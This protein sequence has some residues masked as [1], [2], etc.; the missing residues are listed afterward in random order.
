MKFPPVHDVKRPD[1]LGNKINPGIL[2]PGRGDVL[3]NLERLIARLDNLEL[4]LAVVDEVVVY[5][6][7]AQE[8]A[9]ALDDGTKVR[10]TARWVDIDNVAAFDAAGV[11]RSS[12]RDS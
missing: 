4:V 12:Q 3:D 7:R 1:V 5:R 2:V 8:L 9:V 11:Q 10:A 6:S